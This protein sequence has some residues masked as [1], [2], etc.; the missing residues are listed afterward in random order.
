MKINEIIVE[1]D[2]LKG[3]ARKAKKA[4]RD[5]SN[6]GANFGRG[7]T[8]KSKRAGRDISGK[9]EKTGAIA[10]AAHGT[11]KAT[12]AVAEPAVDFTRGVGHEL[13]PREWGQ[14]AGDIGTAINQN[15]A[16]PVGSLF[17]KASDKKEKPAPVGYK[18]KGQKYTW[19]KTV[20]G[21]VNDRGQ[22]A[23]DEQADFLENSYTPDEP[24]G[25]TT[26]TAKQ[27]PNQQAKTAQ[28]KQ[29]KKPNIG[30]IGPDDPR[31]ADLEAKVKN[32]KPTPGK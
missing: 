11:G 6:I 10:R 16:K 14:Y 13:H 2:F 19:T 26:N 21:W 4:G 3:M 30:G 25:P 15:T 32:A 22:R 7:L 8:G 9:Y 17:T 20:N 28:T 5:F 23:N 29:Q 24:N 18:F 31:Y 27:Q 1:D 12:R